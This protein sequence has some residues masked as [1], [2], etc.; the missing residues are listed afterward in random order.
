MLDLNINYET[1]KKKENGKIQVALIWT[2][3]TPKAPS[4]NKDLLN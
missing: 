2:D 4:G 3:R 1:I